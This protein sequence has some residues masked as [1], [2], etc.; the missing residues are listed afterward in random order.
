MRVYPIEDSRPATTSPRPAPDQQG[1]PRADHH[2]IPVVRRPG[3]AGRRVLR[4]RVPQLRDPAGQPQRRRR[5]RGPGH[6]HVGE[7]RDRRTAHRGVQRWPRPPVHRSH[8]AVRAG[9]HPGRDRPP[10]GPPAG[11]RRPGGP[12]RLAQG[13]VGPVLADRPDG[14][15]RAPVRPRTPAAR[16]APCRRCSAWSS[17]TSLRWRRRPTAP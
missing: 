14:A 12:V 2:P 16:A 3:R 13:P 7:S 15:A 6:R 17:S 4:V 8:L 5:H 10:L 1:D 9:G 11:G